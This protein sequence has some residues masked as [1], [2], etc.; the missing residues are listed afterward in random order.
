VNLKTN[1]IQC[2]VC[3]SYKTKNAFHARNIHGRHLIEKK[4]RFNIYRCKR[5]NALF[6]SNIDINDDEFYNKYY[7]E[8][9]YNPDSIASFK[10]A[11]KMAVLL[12]RLSYRLKEKLILRNIE[13]IPASILD[14]GCG[15]GIFLSYLNNKKF[16]RYGLEIN[17][18][19]L[20]ICQKKKIP[21]FSTDL[22]KTNFGDIKYNAITLIHVLEH[23]PSP[24]KVL[25]K[26]NKI[27]ETDG[28]LVLVV[29]NNM[30]FGCRIGKENWFHLDC[31]RHLFIP[32]KETIKWLAEASGFRV[33]KIGYEFYD[34]PLDLFWSIRH[35]CLKFLMYPLYPLLKVFSEE[36]NTFILKK[37]QE[38]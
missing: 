16:N 4:E 28:V 17:N 26:I 20:R 15:S 25:T 7:S 22:M 21:V 5:C 36:T 32:S 13:Q 37:K 14:V 2:T 1:S 12:E 11:S 34:Y 29:P 9:Y 31:P 19:G 18:E 27:I 30:S 3:G 35:S 33:K 10:L 23:L 24:V 38:L 8:G 6:V